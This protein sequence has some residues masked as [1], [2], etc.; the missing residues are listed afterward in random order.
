MS[1]LSNLSNWVLKTKYGREELTNKYCLPL[2]SRKQNEK[3][4]QKFETLRLFEVLWSGRDEWKPNN[5]LRPI[6]QRI[7]TELFINGKRELYIHKGRIKEVDRTSVRE[8]TEIGSDSKYRWEWKPIMAAC[9]KWSTPG[10]KE[11]LFEILG[12]LKY[13]K[14]KIGGITIIE[15][16]LWK[17]VWNQILSSLSTYILLWINNLFGFNLKL[18]VKLHFLVEKV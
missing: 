18:I 13:C 5:D 12:I 1:I 4:H 14:V 6:K 9:W 2:S 7:N 15:R 17:Y 10:I 3:Y 8:V 11:N 16:M